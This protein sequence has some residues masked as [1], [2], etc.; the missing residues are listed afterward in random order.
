[1]QFPNNNN[2]TPQKTFVLGA[3]GFIGSH[4]LTKYRSFYP[5]CMGSSYKDE[6]HLQKINLL[7]PDIQHLNLKSK[8]YKNALICAAVT[9]VDR[10]ENNPEQS[11][12]I[13]VEG[14]LRIIEQL[15]NDDIHPIYFSSDYVFDGFTGNYTETSPVNPINLYGTHKAAVEKAIP[16]ICGSNYT[17]LRLS[18]IFSTD[19][20][21]I[22]FLSAMF[23]D[24]V[25]GKTIK[26][27]YDQIFCPT[28]I[29]DLLRITIEIQVKDLKGLF[30]VC[31]P[32]AISRYELARKIALYC[33]VDP[34]NIARIS[35]DD[36]N[37]NFRRP[38]NTSMVCDNIL[39]SIT[40]RFTSIDDCILKLIQNR[41]INHGKK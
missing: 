24:I 17:I 23:S 9:K 19:D 26:A 3:N 27:A 34:D 41:S 7:K 8:G 18:K 1:M 35:I 13:N 32:Q 20:Y 10:C 28:L 29:E 25:A 33:R 14:T 6:E 15:I 11:F 21:G 37:E 16:Q 30:N 22:S 5:D 2:F 38:H 39:N 31:S 40:A 12:A 36:L 4:F